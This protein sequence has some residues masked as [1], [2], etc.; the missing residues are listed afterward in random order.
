MRL[1]SN[2]HFKRQAWGLAGALGVWFMVILAATAHSYRLGDIAIG[3]FWAA[4]TADGAVTASVYGPLL[5]RGKVSVRLVKVSTPIAASAHLRTRDGTDVV[6]LV[7]APGKPLAL[8]A[9]RAHIELDG[10]KRPLVAGES[11][12]LTLDF[13]P[14]GHLPI[15]VMVESNPSD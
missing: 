7:L 2:R 3:H 6:D 5:N 4:P 10:L 15:K 12:D 9:W 11:F 13:G 1:E 14:A 8:A